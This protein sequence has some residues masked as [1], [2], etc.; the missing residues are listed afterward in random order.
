LKLAYLYD[1]TLSID[2]FLVI[3]RTHGNIKIVDWCNSILLDQN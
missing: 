3:A 2:T 1:N